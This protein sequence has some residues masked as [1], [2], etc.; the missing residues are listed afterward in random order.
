MSFTRGIEITRVLTPAEQKK[1]LELTGTHTSGF[2]DHMIYSLALGT[3]MREHE[4]AALVVGDVVRAGVIRTS[5]DLTTFKG[6]TRKTPAPAKV[7]ARPPRPISQ[8]VHVPKRARL[9]LAKFMKWKKRNGES[10]APAAPLFVTR[11]S[12]R[13]VHGEK[14]ATRT[15]RHHFNK[16]QKLAGFE[17]IYGFHALRHTSLSNL[18]DKTKDLRLTQVQARHASSQTTERYTH[19][20]AHARK[21]VE[22]MPC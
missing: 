6:S 5:I 15:I 12:W 3:G 16:W 22:D 14:L 20:D 13:S 10:L 17:T 1:L 8:L 19:V 21:A 2:R 9:K 11:G 18:Y 4:I 7:G